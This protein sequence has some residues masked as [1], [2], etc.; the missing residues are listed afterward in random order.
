MED[1]MLFDKYISQNDCKD[2]FFLL[3]HLV[4]ARY[5]RN[6]EGNL[7]VLLNGVSGPATFALAQILTGGGVRAS[8]E[9]NAQSEKLLEKIN[10]LLDSPDCLG[11]EVIV[12]VTIKPAEGWDKQTYLDSREVMNC[13]FLINNLKV[14]ERSENKISKYGP[15]EIKI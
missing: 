10:A 7:V 9:M 2:Q 6:R 1:P 3:G 4:I 12:R 14:N 15:K 11:V 5:P 13:D 8:K